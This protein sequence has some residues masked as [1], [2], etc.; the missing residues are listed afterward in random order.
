MARKVFYSFHYKPDNVRASQ[1]RNIGVV[2]GNQPASDNEWETITN[3]G[4]TA[5][6]NWIDDQLKGRS[7][8][9]VLIGEKTA[10]RKWIKYEIEKSWNDGKGVVGIYIPNLKNFIGEQTNKGRN[11]FEDFTMKRDDEKLSN[12]VKAYNPPYTD[13]KKVYNYISENISD[14]IEEAITIRNNY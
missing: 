13:S 12:I 5:I 9:I 6:K 7:C 14:W 2:K 4:E 11:P 10:G 3:G 1:I 8:T